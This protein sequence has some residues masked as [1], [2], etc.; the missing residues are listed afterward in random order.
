LEL[1][2]EWDEDKGK[3]GVAELGYDIYLLAIAKN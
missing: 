3:S 2:F 1:K